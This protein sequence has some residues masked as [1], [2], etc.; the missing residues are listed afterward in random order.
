MI[1]LKH[2]ES[3]GTTECHRCHQ[4]IDG[5]GFIQSMFNNELICMDCKEEEKKDPD[6]QLAVWRDLEEYHRRLAKY[7]ADKEDFEE[8]KRQTDLADKYYNKIYN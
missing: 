4:K 5:R 1:Y 3:F 8:A 7:A 2:F 6:Y